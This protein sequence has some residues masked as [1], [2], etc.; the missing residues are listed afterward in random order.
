MDALLEIGSMDIDRFFVIIGIEFRFKFS[1][2]KSGESVE[3]R[4]DAFRF[5]E[6]MMEIKEI[7]EKQLIIVGFREI[8]GWVLL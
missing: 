6:K 1:L 4:E 5:F 7:T 3:E 2:K 8:G